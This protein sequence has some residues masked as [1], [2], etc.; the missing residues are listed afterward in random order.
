MENRNDRNVYVLG[1]GLA[2]LSCAWRLAEGGAN[3]VVLEKE[4]VIAGC[5]RSFEWKGMVHDMGPHRWHSKDEELI[6][7]LEKLMAGNLTTLERLSRIFLY[8]KYFNYPL[9]TGNVVRNL[10]PRVLLRAFI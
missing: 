4:P 5:A 9:K 8:K 7:H 2:G 3:V 6:A 10:P 1:A